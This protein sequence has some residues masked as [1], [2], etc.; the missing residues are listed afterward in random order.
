[1]STPGKE[2]A[3]DALIAGVR[4][5]RMKEQLA[6]ENTLRTQDE[7]TQQY[8]TLLDENERLSNELKQ[9]RKDIAAINALTPIVAP[10][11]EY[12]RHYY[13]TMDISS[14]TGHTLYRGIKEGRYYT[15]KQGKKVYV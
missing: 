5:L 12:Y 14:A 6:H 4:E 13:R 2:D 10:N 15:N 3:L 7:R 11:G 1:M 9:A 8:Q